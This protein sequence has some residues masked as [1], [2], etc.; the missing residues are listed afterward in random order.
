MDVSQG[1]LK[2]FIVA[3]DCGTVTVLK[4]LSRRGKAFSIGMSL[5]DS[6]WAAV[7][8]VEFGAVFGNLFVVD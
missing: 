7:F 5:D 2:L 4:G 1:A 3:R 8:G 6:D